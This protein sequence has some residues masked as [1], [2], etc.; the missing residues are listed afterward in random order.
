MLNHTGR[1]FVTVERCIYRY[2]ATLLLILPPLNF[3]LL[4]WT[5]S[6]FTGG[7][8]Y[9]QALLIGLGS[10][11]FTL[12]AF[13]RALLL[14]HTDGPTFSIVSILHWVAIFVV[15][16][17]L[18]NRTPLIFEI[19]YFAAGLVT[20]CAII[21]LLQRY[22]RLRRAEGAAEIIDWRLLRS[23]SAHVLVQTALFGAQPFL[24]NVI[25][26]RTDPSLAAAG[27]FNVSSL[28]V[29]L[30]NVLVALVAPVLL[31]RWS[32]SLDWAGY[33]SVRR[34]ALLAATVVQVGALITLPFV[35]LVLGLFFG[36]GFAAASPSTSILLLS[37]FAVVAGRVLTPAMQ[38]LGRN[39]MVS[40][41]CVVRVIAIAL[42][43]LA[44]HRFGQSPLIAF[45]SGWAVGE[46]AALAFLLASGRR[47][48]G[49]HGNGVENC[50]PS[51]A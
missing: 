16:I 11:L 17:L 13:L 39:D 15:S 34:H 30:P 28:V 49:G 42:T 2:G 43:T 5:G 20:V 38:G 35:A 36:R 45:A 12:F 40:W 22:Q 19:A 32:R 26:A 31:N 51:R 29:T 50:S 21:P 44:L 4:Q 41:S 33:V 37:A 18:L 27:L 10:G 48:G 3:L 1:G 6:R 14:V 8:E 47:L 24:T 46:Y 7:T 9:L 23:Q 25:L